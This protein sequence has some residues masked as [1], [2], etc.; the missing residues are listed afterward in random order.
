MGMSTHVV[1]F[2]PV[3]DKFSQMKSV[4]DACKIAGISPPDEVKS[5]FGFSEPDP[6]GFEVSLGSALCEWSNEYAEGFE[7]NLDKLDPTIRIVRFYNSW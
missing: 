3:D 6:N 4:W 2:R 7:L 5:F 1:G